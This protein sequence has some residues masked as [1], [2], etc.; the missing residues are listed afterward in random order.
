MVR[1][2]PLSDGIYGIVSPSLKDDIVGHAIYQVGHVEINV[3]LVVG[4][5]WGLLCCICSVSNAVI[6]STDRLIRYE[7]K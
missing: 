1:G 7:K 3:F 2:W 4:S 6:K 5:A